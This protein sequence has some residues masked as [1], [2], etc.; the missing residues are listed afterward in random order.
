MLLLNRRARGVRIIID[1]DF[2]PDTTGTLSGVI[3]IRGARHADVTDR[4]TLHD[5]RTHRCPGFGFA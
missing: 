5:A 3:Q 1:G 4:A 2:T